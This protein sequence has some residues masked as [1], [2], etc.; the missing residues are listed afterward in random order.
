MFLQKNVVGT[1][2]QSQRVW[3]SAT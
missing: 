2:K 3:D 1:I